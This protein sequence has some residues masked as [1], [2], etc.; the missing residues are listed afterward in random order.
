MPERELV[1]LLDGGGFFEAPRWRESRW[2]VSDLY[3]GLVLTVEPDGS[4]SEMMKVAGQPSGIGWLPDGS[5]LV[6]S[7]KDQRILRLSRSGEP[8]VHADLSAFCS[9]HLNDMV[10]DRRG[11]A[12]VGE[13]GFD[14]QGFA[15]PAPAKLMRVDPDGEVTV[16]ADD[17]MFPNGAVITPDGGTLIVGETAGSRYTAFSLAEDGSVQERHTWAQVAPAPELGPLAETLPKLKFGPDG[18]TLDRE[19]CIWA[20]DAVGARCARVAEGGEIVDEIPAPEGL[21]IFACM[22]GG[23]D[24]RT[25]LMAAAPDFLEI[26]RAG[27]RDAVLL[28][29]TVDVPHAGLP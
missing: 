13:F 15:D 10:L 26:N 24:G 28:T 22:L 14:L 11:R 17:L 6:V 1:R 5:M 7:M 25:L 21:G 2:W 9:G 3:R 20:A 8:V 12:Y 23:A 18:C 27:A 19:G 29:T 4:T 16:L